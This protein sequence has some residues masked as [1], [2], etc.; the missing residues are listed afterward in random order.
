MIRRVFE[1]GDGSIKGGTVERSSESLDFALLDLGL[2]IGD[3]GGET[4]CAA[5][6]AEGAVCLNGVV[7]AKETLNS[8]F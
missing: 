7:G 4:L 3:V 2:D 6:L 5:I 1:G 8:V